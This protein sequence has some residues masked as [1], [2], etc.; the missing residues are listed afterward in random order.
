[1]SYIAT[2]EDQVRSRYPNNYDK[3]ER[4]SSQWGALELARKQTNDPN[5]FINADTKRLIEENSGNQGEVLN[6]VL[7]ART[8]TIGNSISCAVPSDSDGDAALVAIATPVEYGWG[9][10]A[11]EY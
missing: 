6:P 8:V 10:T 4:R 1:M 5:N 2:I 7:N 9:F 11:S 3:N